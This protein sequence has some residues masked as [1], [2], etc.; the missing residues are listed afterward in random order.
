[1]PGVGARTVR[2]LALVAVFVIVVTISRYVSLGSIIASAL[3]PMALFVNGLPKVYIAAGFVLSVW[4]IVR[5]IPNIRR[6]LSGTE[7]RFGARVHPPGP[8]M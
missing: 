5:H 6:L 4:S 7:S 3:L 1:M 8:S 2:A